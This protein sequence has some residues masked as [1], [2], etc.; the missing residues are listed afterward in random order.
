MLADR[1]TL[2]PPTL[3]AF[4]LVFCGS[5]WQLIIPGTPGWLATF[6]YYCIFPIFL[7]WMLSC[8]GYLMCT[9]AYYK[10]MYQ[11]GRPA[12]RIAEAYADMTRNIR[13]MNTLQMNHQIQVINAL[14]LPTQFQESDVINI[15]GR[16]VQ[17]SSVMEYINK[18]QPDGTMP[19]V[20][21]YT[22]EPERSDIRH[23]ATIIGNG[24]AV[25]AASNRGSV[26]TTKELL[27]Q[28]IDN[29]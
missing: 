6:A 14:Q 19:P 15:G 22:R 1:P 21:N 17:V 12:V 27:H 28:V 5:L 23:L 2:W 11:L 29:A 10:A 8:V 9:A 20:R 7:V 26:K 24:Y 18:M 3:L 16:D 4:V 13:G 25:E